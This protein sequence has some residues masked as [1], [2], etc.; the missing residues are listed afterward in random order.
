MKLN[1]NV[2]MKNCIAIS[3]LAL[4]VAATAEPSASADV[5]RG[6]PHNFLSYVMSVPTGKTADFV[7]SATSFRG[8]GVEWDAPFGDS[9]L[10][11]GLSFRWI[12]FRDVEENGTLQS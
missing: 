4:S 10:F 3:A 1:M 6:I 8:L 9:E 5:G 7:G 2:K 11:W 12:Y